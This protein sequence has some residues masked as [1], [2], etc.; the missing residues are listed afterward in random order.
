MTGGSRLTSNLKIPYTLSFGRRKR[1][2]IMLDPDG[3]VIAYAPMRT[4]IKEI[5]HFIELH[6]EWIEKQKKKLLS[7]TI[8]KRSDDPKENRRKAEELKTWAS[9]FLSEYEGKKPN[10]ITIR[11]MSSR[12]GSCSSTGHISLNLYL[13]DIDEHLREYVLI[14]ELSHL[15]QMNHSSLFW[16]KVSEKCPDYMERRRALRR[17]MLPGK[18]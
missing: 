3:N 13:A 18:T 14:H 1:L 9:A 15:Y 5:D 6:S 12:W 11:V 10:R 17:I 16:N 8:L 4:A 2:K 7:K